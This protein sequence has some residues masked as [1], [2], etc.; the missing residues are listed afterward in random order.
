MGGWFNH[1]LE[2]FRVTKGNKQ[3]WCHQP[4]L[5]LLSGSNWSLIFFRDYLYDSSKIFKIPDLK[6]KHEE[7]TR[8]GDLWKSYLMNHGQPSNYNHLNIEIYVS[9]WTSRVQLRHSFWPGYL[10]FNN[11]RPVENGHL[12]RH[13]RRLV[14][15]KWWFSKGIPEPEC[16]SFGL[17]NLWYFGFPAS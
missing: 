13:P 3:K 16:H 7:L 11:G 8:T 14:T 17:R 15:G 2:N 5:Q 1:Q 9:L 10:W 12:R 4:Q 6:P